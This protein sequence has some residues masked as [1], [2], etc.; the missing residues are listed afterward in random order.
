MSENEG[1]FNKILLS[2]VEEKKHPYLL[3]MYELVLNNRIIKATDIMY[4]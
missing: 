4:L 1:N 2:I 3:E